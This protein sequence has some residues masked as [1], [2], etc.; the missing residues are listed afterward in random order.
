[1]SNLDKFIT[2]KEV[3]DIC[4]FKTTFIYARIRQGEFPAPIKFGAASR[5]SLNAI[6]NWM[7]AKM[8][9]AA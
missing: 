2:I 4:G 9:E 7:T 3:A 8:R 1:M 5:W 6:Q